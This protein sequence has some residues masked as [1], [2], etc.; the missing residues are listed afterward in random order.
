MDIPSFLA[1]FF[2]AFAFLNKISDACPLD[3]IS[4][5]LD[6]FV[7]ISSSNSFSC[8]TGLPTKFFLSLYFEFSSLSFKNFHLLKNIHLLENSFISLKEVY[9]HLNIFSYPFKSLISH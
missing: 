5:L 7:R 3:R 8:K 2:S 1:I 9:S 6:L 4:K